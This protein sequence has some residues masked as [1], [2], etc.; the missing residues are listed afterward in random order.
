MP[1]CDGQTAQKDEDA[2]TWVTVEPVP[3]WQQECQ[4][5]DDDKLFMMKQY[6][7]KCC[8]SSFGSI[9]ASKGRL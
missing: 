9:A 2:I 6:C 3:A 1:T 8:I 7:A 4:T 5:D